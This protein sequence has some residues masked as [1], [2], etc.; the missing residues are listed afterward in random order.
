MISLNLRLELQPEEWSKEQQEF[1]R[2][3]VN[4]KGDQMKT[5][6]KWMVK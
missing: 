6:M 2:I 3:L 5:V 4:T 1:P